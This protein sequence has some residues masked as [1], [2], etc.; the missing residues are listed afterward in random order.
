[1]VYWYALGSGV[2]MLAV[3]L[4]ARL[5]CGMS[6]PR[7]WVF[8]VLSAAGIWLGAL[9][10]NTARRYGGGKDEFRMPL[11]VRILG[12]GAVAGVMGWLF[13]DDLAQEGVAVAVTKLVA[14]VLMVATMVAVYRFGREE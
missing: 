11:G 1:M 10:G 9:G 4:L 2:T 5:W 7:A 3:L 13:A 6:M 12:W 8:A 14:W